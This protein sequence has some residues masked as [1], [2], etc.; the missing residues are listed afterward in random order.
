[1]VDVG[2]NGEAYVGD[3]ALLVGSSGDLAITLASLAE[4]LNTIIYE[5]LVGFNE[6][7]LRIYY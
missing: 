1:M 6:R 4:K 5:V 3:E 2:T 7:I